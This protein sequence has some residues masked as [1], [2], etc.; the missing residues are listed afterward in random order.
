MQGIVYLA[1]NMEILPKV[2]DGTQTCVLIDPPYNSQKTQTLQ[3]I[4]VTADEDGDRV[5]FQ[6]KRYKTTVLGEMSYEDKFDDFVGFLRPRFEHARRIL[7]TNGSLYSFID[8]R[9]DHHLRYLLDDIFGVNN[10]LNSIRW[11]HMVGGYRK[12]RWP[13]K[14]DTIYYYAKET[15]H[16]IFNSEEID[17][18]PYMA[19]GMVTPEK[20]ARGKIPS[21]V[22]V[23]TICCGRERLGY[24]TQKPLRILRRMVQASTRAGDTIIDFFAGSGSTGAAALELGRKFILVDNNPIAF[25]VMRQRFA[26]QDVRFVDASA[27]P[28][29]IETDLEE[30][31]CA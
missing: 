20:A 26:G 28:L 24:P 7:S 3:S 18:I 12:D 11:S 17:R 6:G 5:G 9:S 1:E 31:S 16:H 15:G 10:Y 22:W 23:E 2:P 4:S 14:H 21:D 25:D 19:P 30:L 29:T 27:Q 8:Y 13:Q